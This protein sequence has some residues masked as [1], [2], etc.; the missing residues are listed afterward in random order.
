MRHML[1]SFIIAGT[2]PITA[3]ADESSVEAEVE[4]AVGGT[5]E[6][7]DRAEPVVE[8][9][10]KSHIEELADLA[11]KKV[12]GALEQTADKITH[13][14]EKQEVESLRLNL[15]I[16]NDHTERMRLSQARSGIPLGAGLIVAGAGIGY[17]LYDIYEDNDGTVDG[18]GKAFSII[19][20]GLIAGLGAAV[21]IDSA[22]KLKRPS[23]MEKDITAYLS[24]NEAGERKML[25]AVNAVMTENQKIRKMKKTLRWLT[26]GVG[27]LYTTAGVLL[28]VEQDDNGS[29]DHTRV[30][31]GVGLAGLGV[32]SMVGSFFIEDQTFLPG[33]HLE[34]TWR[35][36]NASWME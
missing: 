4:A 1:M 28:A 14:A 26:F 24:D 30:G 22:F 21:M 2:L 6:I 7:E 27:A 17:G 5:T 16:F 11:M 33:E 31:F 12:K 18:G 35:A 3:W 10:L 29:Y 13:S 9:T 19:T 25:K 15:S 8:D 32:G 20:G 36:S 23:D 34:A